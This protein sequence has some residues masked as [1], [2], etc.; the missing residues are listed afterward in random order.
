MANLIDHF[1]EGGWGMFPTLLFGVFLLAVS[2]RYAR[3]PERRLV[4]LIVG[5]GT[6]TMSAGALGF[7]TGLITTCACV[8]EAHPNE[9]TVALQG[10]GESLNNVAFALLFVVVAAIAASIGALQIAR[11]A[12]VTGGASRG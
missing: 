5:L 4:P 12:A 6:L 10:L 7:V 2:V 11:A 9:T 3:S 1:H 8:A